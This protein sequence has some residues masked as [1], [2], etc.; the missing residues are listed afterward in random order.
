MPD[1]RINRAMDVDFATDSGFDKKFFSEHYDAGFLGDCS[2]NETGGVG[3]LSPNKEFDA[4]A[5]LANN[6][7]VLLANMHP[8]AHW[9]RY[10]RKEKRSFKREGSPF[11]GLTDRI[12]LRQLAKDLTDPGENWPRTAFTVHLFYEE[13]IP[14][15][16]S[17]LKGVPS[18]VDVFVSSPNQE[19]LDEFQKAMKTHS[20]SHHLVLAKSENRGRNFGP[21][22]VEFGKELRSYDV[23]GHIHTKKSLYTG[24]PRYDWWLHAVS[25]VLTGTHHVQTARMLLAQSEGDF[26][27]VCSAKL[28]ELPFWAYHDLKNGPMLQKLSGLLGRETEHDYG[29]SDY[30]VG[31]M[32]W[33]SR[34]VMEPLL[35]RNWAYT[36]FPEEEG[37]TDG[38]MQHAIERVI[39][40][41]AADN[42]LKTLK[43]LPGKHVYSQDRK[44]WLA[45]MQSHLSVDDAHKR[46]MSAD[47]VSF[48][49]F[50]TLLYRKVFD[51]NHARKAVDRENPGYWMK[52]VEAESKCRR[53]LGPRED[54]GVADIAI[55]MAEAGDVSVVQAFELMAQEFEVDLSFMRKRSAVCDLVNYARRH[56]KPVIYISDMYLSGAEI[57]KILEKLK[58]PKPD[59]LFV[60]SDLGR[61]KD[62]GDMWDHIKTL[63]FGR[64]LHFGDNIVS[65]LQN[66][67]DRGIE[68]MYIPAILEKCEVIGVLLNRKDRE[69]FQELLL[70]LVAFYGEHPFF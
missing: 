36:D 6:R 29:Y 61:R 4:V 58:I 59:H 55:A 35:A 33:A 20:R 14:W 19:M 66:A 16:V 46:I 64:L 11:V 60:S 50:D 28:P 27:L 8:V 68:N 42:G 45:E 12:T 5:Y 2:S 41:L 56:G 34:K 48:D 38:T 47:T 51:V 23:I 32:F 53:N 40:H 7:D 63:G 24:K 43:W 18:D 17:L 37:Q 70:P 67:T 26:G 57:E 30:P 44:P 39:G 21:M 3:F 31:G 52:R 13:Y 62:R 49:I 25:G 69:D 65:D 54:V 15:I 10:G 1:K 22:L 9:M